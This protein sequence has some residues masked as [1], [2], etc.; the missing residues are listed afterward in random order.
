M[1]EWAEHEFRQNRSTGDGATEGDHLASAERQWERLKRRPRRAIIQTGPPFPDE[2][3]YLWA[4][5]VEISA[6]L[7]GSGFGPP[8]MTWEAIR[9]WQAL[10][11]FGE[12]EPWEARALV[13][14]GLL[15]ASILADA[16]KKRPTDRGGR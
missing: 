5:F 9:A 10:T 1:I 14:L 7:A 11:G 4:A 2:L 6:G 15:R 12:I 3:G 8:V 16:Q 13:Q